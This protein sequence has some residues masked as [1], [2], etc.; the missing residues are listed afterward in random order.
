MFITGLKDVLKE[1]VC[2]L[3]TYSLSNGF[4][5]VVSFGDGLVLNVVAFAKE[6]QL[7]SAFAFSLMLLLFGHRMSQAQRYKQIT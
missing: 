7:E 2:S 6:L 4:P 3:H 5:G 1:F